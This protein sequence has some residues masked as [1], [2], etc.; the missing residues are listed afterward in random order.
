M[1]NRAD[2]MAA[3]TRRSPAA[4]T[5]LACLV[6][7]ACTTLVPH[8][9]RAPAPVPVSPAAVVDLVPEPV[10]PAASS[11]VIPERLLAPGATFTL[12]DVVE[13]AL[14]NNPAT[15]TSY[16]QALAA[17]AQLGSKRAV[18]YPTLDAS[19]SGSRGKVSSDGRETTTSSTWGPALS[20]S[21]L[22]LDLGGRS[23]GAEEARQSVLAADWTH[24][25]TV[26]TVILVVQQTY[27]GYLTAKAQLNAAEV[28]V[29]QAEAALDAATWRHQAGVATIAEVLQART[30][31]SEARLLLQSATGQVSVVR[32]LLATAMG[33]PANTSLDVGQLP[34][35]VPSLERVREPIEALIEKAQRQRPDLAAARALAEKAGHHIR[36]VRSDGLPALSLSASLSRSYFDPAP[37]ADYRNNWS[38]TLLVDIPLFTGFANSYNIEKA[39]REA[40]VA[41]AQVQS[42][43]Q[44][45]ILQVWTSYY[46]LKTALQRIATARDLL[47][48]A[49]QSEQVQLGR[50]KEGVGTFLD[51]L[52]AQQ[53]L[54]NARAQEI[55]ARSDAFVALAHLIFDTG[56]AAQL[57]QSIAIQQGSTT[58]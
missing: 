19:V 18:Y 13:V 46:S 3:G 50:Y 14:Q 6:L 58:P 11:P 57:D 9:L 30:A 47:A 37:F 52:A 43:E 1:S 44:Q 26:Q 20:L 4:V 31:V 10:A 55:Q 25:A 22:L 42:L 16:H 5:L 21:Y 54:V 32:G 56:S 41:A 15:A 23:A 29:K 38:A 33:L 2:R 35:E 36:S 53:Q 49:E 40:A 17:A 12:A 34:V 8:G 7:G 39:K 28:T 48:S 45:V 24:N 27:Y 51:V